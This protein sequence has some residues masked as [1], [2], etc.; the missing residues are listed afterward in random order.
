MGHYLNMVNII[1]LSGLILSDGYYLGKDHTLKGRK[2][3]LPTFLALAQR[4]ST[5]LQP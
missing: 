2:G 1:A 5:T 4:A 3:D